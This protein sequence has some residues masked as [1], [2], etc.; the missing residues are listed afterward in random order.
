MRTINLREINGGKYRQK[1]YY[2][3]QYH[4]IEIFNRPPEKKPIK[5]AKRTKETTPARKALNDKKGSDHFVR[6][7]NLNF[8]KG[9]FSLDLTFAKG[10]MPKSIKELEKAAA[11]FIRRCK[12]AVE[13]RH[14]KKAARS[15]K[16]SYVVSDRDEEGNKARKHVHMLIS[17]VDRDILKEKWTLG[18]INIDDLQPDENGIEGKSRYMINQ[19]GAGKKR[20][21]G[22]RNLKMPEVVTSDNAVTEKEARE[23]FTDPGNRAYFEKKYKGWT[24]TDC[25]TGINEYDGSYYIKI[26]M[27]KEENH[28]R[29][30]KAAKRGQTENREHKTSLHVKDSRRGKKGT[31]RRSDG[32]YGERSISICRNGRL[33]I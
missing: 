8:V 3:G 11:N 20:W 9:D 6:V 26:K 24:F 2:C 14:G 13:K 31:K 28:E 17:G 27:R 4:E 30:K 15:V 7:M 33:R 23:M 10:N 29:R 1:R 22:S 5:K 12:R 32:L 21:I 18:R 25:Q 16:Y 19:A